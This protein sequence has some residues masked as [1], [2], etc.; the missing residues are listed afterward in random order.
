[1]VRLLT[2]ARLGGYLAKVSFV[3]RVKKKQSQDLLML[4]INREIKQ[5]LVQDFN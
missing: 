5:C 3:F 1:M 2:D 4:Q